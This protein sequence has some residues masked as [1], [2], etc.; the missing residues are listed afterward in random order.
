MFPNITPAFNAE[1]N[2][3]ELFY[4]PGGKYL[5]V[6][7]KG[8]EPLSAAQGGV[9]IPPT[10]PGSSSMMISPQLISQPNSF[11]QFNGFSMIPQDSGNP[12]HQFILCPGKKRVPRLGGNIVSQY[13]PIFAMSINETDDTRSSDSSYLLTI[14]TVNY[15][16]AHVADYALLSKEEIR[17]EIVRFLGVGVVNNESLATHHHGRDMGFKRGKLT[18]EHLCFNGSCEIRQLWG[19]NLDPGNYI[20]FDIEKRDISKGVNYKFSPIANIEYRTA[21][22][23]WQIIPVVFKDKPHNFDGYLI[24]QVNKSAKKNNYAN[25]Q[26]DQMEMNYSKLVEIFLQPKAPFRALKRQ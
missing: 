2:G 8:F 3:P 4:Q 25:I 20:G 23:V 9:H 1:Q 15:I 10:F 26:Y 5:K 22:P 11:R 6:E 13:H 18:I 7:K 12:V 24:G 21:T 17:F 14:E 16:L 19:E